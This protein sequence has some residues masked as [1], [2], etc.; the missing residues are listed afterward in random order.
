MMTPALE[1]LKDA[2]LFFSRDTPS[3]A[4][5]ILVMDRIDKEFATRSTNPNAHKA[6]CAAVAVA[7]KT[8]NRYYAHTDFSDAY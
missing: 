5:I 6:I 3:L 2:T 8:L 7:K 4:T 1:I